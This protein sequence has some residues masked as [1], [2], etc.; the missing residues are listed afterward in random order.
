M[1]RRIGKCTKHVVFDEASLTRQHLT[2]GSRRLVGASGRDPANY[3]SE[4][5]VLTDIE[6]R[7]HPYSDVIRVQF[8]LRDSLNHGFQFTP[9]VPRNRIYVSG[10]ERGSP[11]ARISNK[12]RRLRH[13]YLI[14]VAGSHVHN[15]TDLPVIL[16]K[17]SI[18]N[19]TQVEWIFAPDRGKPSDHTPTP[20]IL[21]HMDQLAAARS[22]IS[23]VLKS[24]QE[25]RDADNDKDDSTDTMDVSDKDATSNPQNGDD[26][27]W[28]PE[29]VQIHEELCLLAVAEKS[30]EPIAQKRNA[31][32]RQL[33]KQ[34]DWKHWHR[35]EFK[36]LDEYF[37]Q[38]MYGTPVEAHTIPKKAKILSSVWC[39]ALKHDGRY[40]AR[41][42][43]NG[44]PRIVRGLK[45]KITMAD[46]YAASLSQTEFR[47]YHAL[48]AYHNWI[49]YGA[50]ATNAF[51][52]SP[53]PEGT[54]YMR[55]DAQY[56]EWYHAKYPTRP[57]ITT[58]HLLPVQHA[59]QGHPESPRL[60]EMFVSEKLSDKG[61]TSPPHAPCIYSGVYDGQECFILRQ[62]DDFNVATANKD[63]A[64]KLYNELHKEFALVQESSHV[65]RM[66]GVNVEQTRNYIKIHLNDYI[67]GMIKQYEWMQGLSPDAYSTPI[68]DD[69]GKKLDEVRVPPADSQRQELEKQFGF[70]FRELMGKLIFAM[71]C[72]RF[73]I[74][75]ELSRL[76]QYNENPGALHYD[77]LR[78]VAKHLV[79]TKTRGLIYWRI[80]SRPELPD[81]PL[82]ASPPPINTDSLPHKDRGPF[83]LE[84]TVVRPQKFTDTSSGLPFGEVHDSFSDSNHAS[85]KNHRRSL[86][87]SVIMFNG[88]A[89]DYKTVIQSSVSF[90]SCE[91]E[92][93]ALAMTAKRTKYIRHILVGLGYKLPGPTKIW[94]DNEGAR[95]VTNATGTTKR[96]RHVDIPYFALQEWRKRKEI[97]VDRIHTHANPSD[98]F[99]KSL[100]G[101]LYNRHVYRLAGYYGPK[102][103]N[104][105]IQKPDFSTPAPLGGLG[106][107]IQSRVRF[108][109]DSPANTQAPPDSE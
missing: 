37:N 88:T 53:P 93:V 107:T 82:D 52:Y 50:D 63:T 10:T 7:P 1:S 28:T 17:L 64:A 20:T 84:A 59:L 109:V 16:A 12:H 78:S 85:D 62:V 34:E 60:W 92:L 46:T 89:I 24:D 75:C 47:I 41:N 29:E 83:D 11:G 57:R 32:R 105:T 13:A 2:P 48:A 61:F 35:A 21:L 95:H 33:Q 42:V 4:A 98:M 19:P 23:E 22:V 14:S 103:Y 104:L 15:P 55:V 70:K 8:G 68:T 9:S 76:S 58:K 18:D 25:K 73:D 108:K 44:Q 69:M 5:S 66:Y 49:S 94:C 77:A 79:R 3:T 74:S 87:G 56:V 101:Q 38:E 102:S 27:E 71:V 96:L 30:L 43:C 86:S 90:S 45:T 80:G 65:T 40:K 39:Y 99:T 54:V 6:S 31:T 81:V 51:A 67:D 26:D 72:G 91:A 100:T 36:M 97:H 106:N